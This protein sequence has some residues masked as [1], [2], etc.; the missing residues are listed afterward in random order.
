MKSWPIVIFEK[1]I[2]T[3]DYDRMGEELAKMGVQGIEATVRKG[4]HIEA[5]DAEIEVPKMVES[6]AKNGQKALI[7]TCN[8]NSADEKNA[9]FLRIL[10]AN[11]ITRYR[12]DY[13][14]YDLK[15]DLLPQV[16]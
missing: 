2:Q 4:G 8:V 15:K 9:D 1:P 14:R 3:L 10:K 6:L 5:K 13:F 11:G 7:A 12:M 16:A